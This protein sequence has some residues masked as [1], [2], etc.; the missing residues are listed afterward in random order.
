MIVSSKAVLDARQIHSGRGSAQLLLPISDEEIHRCAQYY[1]ARYRP[2]SVQTAK[3]TLA[4]QSE[5]TFENIDM[6]ED[7]IVLIL[8]SEGPITVNNVKAGS[9]SV[10]IMGQMS[11]ESISVV[12]A[13][14]GIPFDGRN[15]IYKLIRLPVSD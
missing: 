6:K 14:Y 12:A 1:C 10:L 8:S 11:A 5:N 13:Q 2:A 9:R 3:Y 4:P 15:G 7:D